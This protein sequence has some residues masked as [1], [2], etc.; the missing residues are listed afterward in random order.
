MIEVKNIYGESLLSVPVLADSVSHEELMTSDYVA[1][2]WRSDKGDILPVGS[3]IIYN[4]EKYS[5]LEAYAPVRIDEVEFE[6]KPQFQSRIMRWQKTIVPVY[7]YKEDGMTVKTR[8]LDWNF[9]GTPS[10]AM[11][12]IQQALKN[13]LGET[14]NVTLGADLP[15]TISLSSQSSS[16]W[17][18]LS[19]I[20]ELCE[21][22]WWADKAAN[23]IYLKKYEHGV[24][25]VLEVGGN[26]KT[27]SVTPSTD[28]YF[29]RFYAFGSSRNVTQSEGVVMGSTVNKRLALDPIKYPNGY[30]DIKGHFENGVFVSDLNPDE[31]FPLPLYFEDIYPSS[32]LKISGVRRRMR[33][34]IDNETG[35][36]IKVGGT[37]DNP[38]YDMYPIWYFSIE[39]FEFSEELIIKGQT[40][41]VHFKSG[42]LRGREF[43][44]A[45]HA[46]DKKVADKEDV[47]ENFA[48][49]A[50]EYEI[51]FDQQTEG[52]IIPSVDYIIPADGDEVTLF[53]IEMPSEY[54]AS[55]MQKLEEELDKEIEKR[56]KDNNAYEF[57]SNPAAFYKEGTD[58]SVG[59]RVTFIN[60]GA[61]LDTRVM[62]VE[63][64][65][66]YAFEQRI[67]VGNEIIKGSRQQ[68]KDEVKDVGE[69]V[70][71][72]REQGANSAAVQRGHSRDLVL[73]MSKYFAMKETMDMLQNALDGYTGGISPIT[74][75]TMA[76]M[77]GDESLQYRFTKSREDLTSLDSCPLV[78]DSESKRLNASPC[79]LIHLTL[80]IDSITAKDVRKASDYMS[81]DMDEW[82]SATFDDSEKAYYVYA[83]VGRDNAIGSYAFSETPIKMEAYGGA[84][85]F[86]VGILNSESAGTRELTTLYGFTQILP[87]QIST[88]RITSADGSC[89]FDLATN[90]I[91]GI[92]K[93]KAG[94]EGLENIAGDIN[95]GAQ[96][97]L[98]NSGFTGDYLSERLA[99][100]VVLD[101]TSQM[102]NNP[103]AHWEASSSARVI[104]SSKAASGKGVRI[105]LSGSL[106]QTLY[107]DIVAGEN[108]VV[109]FKA[110]TMLADS[111]S[112]MVVKLGDDV[113]DVEIGAEWKKYTCK[114]M[115]TVSSKEFSISASNIEICDLQLERGTRA[116]AWGISPL[117]NS[118]DRAYYSALKYLADALKGSTVI[119][120]GLVLT[121]LLKLGLW[122]GDTFTEKAGANGLY[123][124]DETPAFWAGG[125][126]EQAE[127]LVMA[128]LDN[129]RAEL[130]EE[131]VASM[132]RFV[133]T[134]GG[135][136]ILNDAIFRGNIYAKDGY[137]SGRLQMSFAPVSGYA[138]GKEVSASFT[139]NKGTEYSYDMVR[140]MPAHS[141]HIRGDAEGNDLSPYALAL[142]NSSEFSGWVLNVYCPPVISKMSGI[143]AI[144]CI[145]AATGDFPAV[146]EGF[147]YDPQTK[148]SDGT[149]QGMRAVVAPTG[150]FFQLACVDGQWMMMNSVIN[151][152]YTV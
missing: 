30:K 140:L 35:E 103:F 115:P 141:S 58:V 145:D 104:N 79:A 74:V 64:H 51:I 37:D 102:E 130:T 39:G 34:Y 109:S 23:Y 11:Y 112:Q 152:E 24:P 44:L 66:D 54:T 114:M 137:F 53:N 86:L 27:P 22:E 52:F 50:G 124:D 12:M 80:G 123:R 98:R 20:A 121:S 150:G 125:S 81:W 31:V 59:Q 96:N 16:I 107:Y 147:I 84:Y 78:Y 129:P 15:A 108:Y 142:P 40:L 46:E 43:E 21:T 57:A 36:R 56:S 1:L 70:N 62:M 82:H 122:N 19:D 76:M 128:Y 18:V 68:L 72:L 26:V 69:D 61:V 93:F 33:Y 9:T 83:V 92:I 4:G 110:S 32:D 135:R 138:T 3:Y 146:G 105:M 55:A 131:Q 133:L 42:Q 5:L 151:M 73:T 71:K 41:S 117:D 111:V 63:K 149:A 118:S 127:Q 132:A 91:G 126:L 143:N 139:T 88:D 60:N 2:S 85:Y 6:Y 25:V 14:W 47:D 8:E 90:E 148:K 7:T 94:S 13:E 17:T 77:V 106:K 10:D 65:L 134:H 119:N 45:Y 48:V 113:A 49:K 101:A 99:D 95:I 75:Q 89:Y 144:V 38:Q 29:S 100:E 28:G 116:T 87:N 120:G 67:R 97:L 136:A